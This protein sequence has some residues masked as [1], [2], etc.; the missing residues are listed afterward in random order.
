MIGLLHCID[1]ESLFNMAA[2]GAPA[3]GS[4]SRRPHGAIA[5]KRPDW[6][7]TIACSDLAHGVHDER[8]VRCERLVDRLAGEDQQLC[9]TVGLNGDL[10]AGS[11]EQHHLG[12]PGDLLP[13]T[14]TCRRA[15]RPRAVWPSGK[16]NVC[17]FCPPSAARPR[18]RWA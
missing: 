17:R 11:V 9:V 15:R 8:A 12:F 14:S 2:K 10:T 7:S 16:V 3:E 4:S 5:P 13:F 18:C 6:K 1:G